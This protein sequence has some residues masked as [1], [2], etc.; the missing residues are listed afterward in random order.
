MVISG[1][2]PISATGVVEGV[3]E[4]DEVIVLGRRGTSPAT[5]ACGLSPK[6]RSTATS[7]ATR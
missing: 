6:L 3:L 4:A 2:I 7:R 1:T 5:T